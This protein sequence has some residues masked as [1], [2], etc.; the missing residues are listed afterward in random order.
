LAKRR[1]AAARSLSDAEHRW[2]DASQAYEDA[3]GD[4]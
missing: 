3:L 2:L 1:A 4:T